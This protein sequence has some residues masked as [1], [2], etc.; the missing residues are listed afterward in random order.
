MA[1]STCPKCN[2]R[3]WEIKLVEPSNARFKQ[4][5]TQC[6]SCGAPAGVL[7]FY[8]A[9]ALLKDQE[10]EIDKLQKQMGQVLRALDTINENIRRIAQM[11]R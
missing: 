11:L 9:G 2:G 10:E 6:S 5:F 7:G 1:L 4:Y 3:F 8:D